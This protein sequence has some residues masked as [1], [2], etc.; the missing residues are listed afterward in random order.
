MM[1]NDSFEAERLDS[2]A[3]SNMSFKLSIEKMKKEKIH[4]D[5]ALFSE[6]LECWIQ[7]CSQKERV[8]SEIT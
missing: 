2:S 6:I 7:T 5:N 3:S 4:L 8:Y 1:N